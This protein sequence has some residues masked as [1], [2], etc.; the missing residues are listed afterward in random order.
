MKSKIV[1][2][3]ILGLIISQPPTQTSVGHVKNR[4]CLLIAGGTFVGGILATMLVMYCTS[5]GKKDNRNNKN[6]NKNTTKQVI[7]NADKK[8][9]NE[10][11]DL[12]EKIS[13]L[14]IINYDGNH[15]LKFQKSDLSITEIFN[16]SK[17][18][19]ESTFNQEIV[20]LPDLLDNIPLNKKD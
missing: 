16:K 10:F 15:I 4:D 7:T 19:T 11:E 2:L 8:E 13:K 1:S 18:S 12:K 5:S 9:N 6:E 14:N 17:K 20:N 3:L